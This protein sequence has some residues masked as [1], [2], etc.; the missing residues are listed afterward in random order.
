MALEQLKGL[1]KSL[2]KN[3]KDL[4]SS[5]KISS[6]GLTDQGLKREN[7]E[8]SFLIVEKNQKSCD[9]ITMGSM[10]AV[11]DGMG[12]HAA[13]ETASKM[14]C[15]GLM[16]YYQNNEILSDHFL[17]RL[18]KITSSTDKEILAHSKEYP[19]MTGMGTTLSVLVIHESDAFIA[20]IGDSRIYR[21][22]NNDMEQL[23]KDHT[24]VQQ[25]VD[26]G[27]LTEEEALTHYLRHV[28]TQAVGTRKGYKDIYVRQEKTKSGDR[29]LICSDGLHDMLSNNE[30]EKIL[31]LNQ[32]PKALCKKLIYKA[33][34]N[35][36][37]DN[38]TV[39]IVFT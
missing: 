9:T 1:T 21:V 16:N 14:A 36:G 25:L 29:F 13:G 17:G 38:V 22:R 10:Y 2:L 19:E 35:G 24:Q 7:N 34:Q 32:T 8:D 12:G 28:I 37:K 31:T 39:V 23:T 6:Y 27:R 18:E 5:K 20:H 26:M 11:A 15:K 33:L 3:V 30:I 4:L